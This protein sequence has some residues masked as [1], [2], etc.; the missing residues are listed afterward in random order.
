M[1]TSGFKSTPLPVVVVPYCGV[2]PHS[3][4][5]PP[6]W[7][8]GT[9]GG[10]D[11]SL[12]SQCKRCPPAPVSHVA[13]CARLQVMQ[14]LSVGVK[15]EYPRARRAIITARWSTRRRGWRRRAMAGRSAS[16]RP[17]TRRCGVRSLGPGGALKEM[18]I[19]VT[20]VPGNEAVLLN[21][22]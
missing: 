13:I 17:C 2:A 4:R 9:P 8:K 19:R 21:G 3:R 7:T 20:V 18:V 11:H 6:K 22:P 1:T 14:D 12:L 15:K 10:Y 5:N 16:R